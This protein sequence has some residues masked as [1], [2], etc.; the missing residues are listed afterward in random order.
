MA[1]DSKSFLHIWCAKQKVNPPQFDVRPTG[2]LC[3]YLCRR[4]LNLISPVTKCLN[5][6]LHIDLRFTRREEPTKIS[7]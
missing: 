5:N 3:V 2:K 7:L 6:S 4:Q 1:T